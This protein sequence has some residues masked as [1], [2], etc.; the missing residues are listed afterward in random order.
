[1]KQDSNDKFLD[2]EEKQQ[3]ISDERLY[4]EIQKILK[5]QLRIS[6]ASGH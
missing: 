1:M 4:K 2:I 3:K 5:G 6:D